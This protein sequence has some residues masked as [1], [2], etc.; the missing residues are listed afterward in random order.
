V[1]VI[2]SAAPA[3][4]ERS[5]EGRDL[6]GVARKDISAVSSCSFDVTGEIPPATASQEASAKLGADRVKR[7][8][9]A[10]RVSWEN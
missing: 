6:L 10:I 9:S 4:E 7:T 1:I 5:D 8:T 2:P 3:L